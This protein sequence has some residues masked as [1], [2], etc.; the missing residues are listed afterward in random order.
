[1]SRE[2]DKKKM[3]TQK[4]L[5][6]KCKE[7]HSRQIQGRAKNVTSLCKWM[8]SCV[9]IFKHRSLISSFSVCRYK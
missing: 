7:K 3:F 9:L 5:D 4:R 8:A 2:N 6:A 1:M